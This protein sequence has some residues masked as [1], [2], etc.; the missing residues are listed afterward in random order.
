MS[1]AAI[2]GLI[3]DRWLDDL[4]QDRPPR[5]MPELAALAPREIAATMQLAR[6]Y[7]AACFLPEPATGVSETLVHRVRED[8]ENQS[9]AEL[10]IAAS[11]TGTAT[12]FGTLLNDVRNQRGIA[13]ADL[14]HALAAPTR[15]IARLETGEL[16]PHRVPPDTMLLLL[17]G[18]R[19][20]SR[21]AIALI[22]EASIRWATA[23]YVAPQTQLGW[24][25]PEV[26]DA[27]KRR[28]LPDT[29]PREEQRRLD[30][31]L[32]QIERYCHALGARLP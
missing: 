21:R 8:T 10:T 27:A 4:A 3:F 16:P 22:R 17:H 28:L 15:T 2:K 13:A 6:W 24:I 5:S 25:D 30:Q 32:A 23:A 19:L 14:E 20:A 9:Q 18:L 29:A 11:A 1:R 26:H 31:E 7:A 12:S